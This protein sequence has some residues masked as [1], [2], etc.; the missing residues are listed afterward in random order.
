MPADWIGIKRPRAE[1][2]SSF[3][4]LSLPFMCS[5]M[6]IAE[7]KAL[8]LQ[9]DNLLLINKTKGHERNEKNRGVCDDDGVCRCLGDG[10]ELSLPLGLSVG[11]RARPCRLAV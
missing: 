7:G 5:R 9:T 2:N 6:L 8:T 3:L 1:T 11:D 10:G 4:L